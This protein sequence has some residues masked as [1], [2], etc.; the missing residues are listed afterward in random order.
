MS[1]KVAVVAGYGSGI[2]AAF[3]RKLVNEG[4]NLALVARTKS[5]LDAAAAGLSVLYHW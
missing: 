4:F 5:K 1:H 2:S 3:S